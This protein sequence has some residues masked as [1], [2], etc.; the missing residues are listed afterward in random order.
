[1]LETYKQY[2]VYFLQIEG[3]FVQGIGFFLTEE[4]EVNDKGEVVSNSTWTYKPPTLDNI[5]RKFFVEIINGAPRSNRILSSK[6]M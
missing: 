3:A 2:D 5:P 1:M 4:Y 6:G